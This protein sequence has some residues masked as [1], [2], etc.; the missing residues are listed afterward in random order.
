MVAQINVGTDSTAMAESLARN[1]AIAA[2][3][4]EGQQGFGY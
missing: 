3:T 4:G 1:L 2:G